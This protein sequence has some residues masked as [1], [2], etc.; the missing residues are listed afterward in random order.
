MMYIRHFM[1]DIQD[2]ES[3]TAG[4]ATEV[5]IAMHLVRFLAHNGHIEKVII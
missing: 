3:C 1:E 2:R 4:S 5:T